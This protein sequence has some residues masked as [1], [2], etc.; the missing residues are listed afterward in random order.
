MSAHSFIPK[1]KRTEH[2]EKALTDPL[3]LRPF[4]QEILTRI[5]KPLPFAKHLKP[6][7]LKKERK[8]NKVRS[9]C[10]YGNESDLT[11]LCA[12]ANTGL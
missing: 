11:F 5:S 6:F 4:I 1:H 12:N 8:K 7:H 10:N 2:K 3:I 9:L